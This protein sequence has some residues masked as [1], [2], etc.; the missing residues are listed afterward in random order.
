[1]GNQTDQIKGRLK[2]AAG[3]LAND[4]S[5]KSEGKADRR[6]GETNE[7]IEDAA[8]KVKDNI[9]HAVDRVKDAISN[10]R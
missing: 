1:M 4:K 8:D 9:E 2:E 5:L 6:Q 10:K 3:A 7:K